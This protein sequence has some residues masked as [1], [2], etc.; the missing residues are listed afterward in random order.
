MFTSLSPVSLPLVGPNEYRF[1]EILLSQKSRTQMHLLTPERGIW[2]PLLSVNLDYAARRQINLQA[3]WP[4]AETVR[5]G[6]L[7]EGGIMANN[8]THET[9]LKIRYTFATL[10]KTNSARIYL[11]EEDE[12]Y[13]AKREVWFPTRR[14]IQI[15]L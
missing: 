15:T 14:L 13:V 5:Q 1:F 12:L 8:E 9:L 4:R 10:L 11:P 7:Q 2:V 3:F 6:F